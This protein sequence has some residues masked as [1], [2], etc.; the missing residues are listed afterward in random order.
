M[1]PIL[2]IGT[3]DSGAG[4]G[5]YDDLNYSEFNGDKDKYQRYILDAVATKLGN[6]VS[7]Y[8]NT[9]WDHDEKSGKDVLLVTVEAY[10]KGVCLDGEW[11]SRNGSTVRGLTKEEFDE[12][13][14]HRQIRLRRT[15][16]S[17][18]IP[19]PLSD[20][21]LDE[22]H[23]DVT[24]QAAVNVTKPVVHVEK[25][26]T[27]K[28]RDNIYFNYENGFIP[29]AACLKFLPDG[30]IEKATD[31]IYDDSGTELILPIYDD[32]EKE[33]FLIL[34]YENGNVGKVPI[35]E[36]MKFD[37]YRQYR[38]YNDS[39]LIFAA[40]A[41]DNEGIISITEEDR[42]EHR[43][44]VRIDTI[45]KIEKCRLSDKGSRIYNEGLASK[46]LGYEIVP[47]ETLSDVKN[48]LDKD[49]RTL[50]FPPQ[51][52]FVGHKRE[53]KRMWNRIGCS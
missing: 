15:E 39:K 33:G 1:N 36:I 30:K 52:C 42:K 41:F 27:S 46:V 35:R 24:P 12:Y 7:N 2:Y 48:I 20:N 17:I 29:Y 19:E 11:L 25:V 45:S 4:I 22:K 16:Q 47:S 51:V 13:N 9:D 21:D 53:I 6:L 37:D 49:I 32:D 28:R 14:S 26:K 38:R 31:D 10:T 43:T 40:I 5:L 50:G 44:M 3:N 18:A 23:A 8:V 34:G